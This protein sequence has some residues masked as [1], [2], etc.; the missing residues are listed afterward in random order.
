MEEKVG[1]QKKIDDFL[2]VNKVVQYS[3][4]LITRYNTSIHLYIYTSISKMNG[5]ELFERIKQVS[6]FAE[7]AQSINGKTDKETQSKRGNLYEKVWDIIIKFGFYPILSN[8]IYDHYDGNINTCKLK[9]VDNLEIYLRGLSVFSKGEGGSSDITLKNKKNGKWVFMSSKFYLD[10][11]NKSIDEY[12]VEKILAV[13]KQH[14]HKYKEFEIYLVVNNKQKVLDTIASSQST[15]NYIKENIHHILD[16]GNLEFCFQNLKDAIQDITIDEVNSKF[17][18]TKVPLLPRFHQELITYKQMKRIDEGE[19]QFLLGAKARSGKTYCIGNLL[20]KYH[21]KY[22]TINAL[23]ITPAPTETLSQFTDELFHKFRDF[24][25]INI[26]EIKKGTDFQKMGLKDKNIIIVSKQLLDDYVFEKKV[27][28]ILQLNLDFIVF[29]ENHFHGTT[30]MSKNILESYSSPK[31]IKVYLTA[32]YAKPLSEWDIPLDCQ[33]FWDIE[34]EQL[35]K[36]RDIQGL[37]EKHGEDVLLFLTEE[38]KEQMLM[39]YDIMPELHILTNMMDSER[40]AEIK[41]RIKDTSYGFSN[42]ALLSGNFPNEVDM[43]LRYITGSNKERD[44]PR[45]KDMSIFGRIKRIAI[46]K[47]SRTRL[48][49]G[50]FTSQLW[51]LP[52]GIGMPIEKVSNH[53]KDRMLKNSMLQRYEIKIVNSKKGYKVKDIKVEIK[54]WESK[55]KKDGK[56]GLILLAGDQLTLGITLDFVD[57]LFLFNDISSS[58]KI[59]QMMYR[60]MT[61]RINNP[62]NDAINDGEKKVGFVVDMNISRVLNTLL[63]YNVHKKDLNVEQ[64]ISY[65]VENNLINIDSDLFENKENKTKLVEKLLHLW[66]ADPVNNL[67]ILLRKIEDYIVNFDTKDQQRLNK[68]FMDSVGDKKI[69]VKIKFDEESDQVLPTGKEIV[70]DGDGYENTSENEENDEE[71]T[72][73]ANISFTKDILPFILP[74]ICILTMSKKN[75]DT[76]DILEMLNII[77]TTPSLLHVFNDQSF[78]WWNKK[79]IIQFIE[80]IVEKYIKRNSSIYNIAIQFKMSL[81]SLIDKPKELVELIDSCLKP[82]QKE[83]QENGEVFTSMSIISEILDNID[84]SYI[85]ACGKSVFTEKGFIWLDPAAGMGNFVVAVYLRLMDGLKLQI[86][87]DEERKKHIIENMLYM[88]E[89]NKKNVFICRQIFDVNGEYKMNIYEGDTLEL[90]I[91]SVWGLQLNSFNVILGNPAY[92]KGGIRSYTGKQLGEKNETIWPKFI[93]KAFEW[94]KPD[95]YLAFINPLSWLKKSHS[96]HNKML[97]KHIVW[98]KLWDDSQSKGMINAD[99]PISLYVLQNTVNSENKKTE[100]ISEIKRKKLTTTSLEYLNKN[101]SIPLA[102]H[103]IFNKLIRFIEKHNCNLDYKT[104]TI[105]ST[106]TKRKLPSEYLLEDMWA[107]DT[108]TLDEG[109]LVK[110]ANEQHPDANKRKLIIANKRGFKGAFIDEGKL[111]LSGTEKIYLLGD[112]LELIL[113]IMKFDISNILCDYTKYRMSFLEKEVCNYIPD[114]RKLGI[115]DITEDEFYKLIGLTCQEIRQIKNPNAN[116]VIEQDKEK[117][118]ETAMTMAM[119]KSRAKPKKKLVIVE[120]A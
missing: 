108:Y 68:E 103:S 80:E 50:D 4:I 101:Y 89:I 78:I 90:D 53:I 70:K 58:D 117:L 54:N 22:S 97:E 33:C 32:T 13:T 92:N 14:S 3:T 87:N 69:N 113:K 38:N 83:K 41:H 39:V 107:I 26:V 71:D 88:S 20:I 72:Q 56:D 19:K 85:K 99:I 37:L 55:A 11:S 79:D 75:R 98:L 96:L 16:L 51:F 17:Y 36:K 9:K 29:D 6:T 116:K 30:I 81:Q 46:E 12:D 120:D 106:G 8:D 105:K 7:L 63:D 24:N 62:E 59:I 23:I 61:E 66:K 104:K 34:D 95:G 52:Y 35:C 119:T 110:K 2:I 64:K 109:I 5:I 112:N 74:L 25:G 27:E 102:F 47:N 84:K 60:C 15:N 86:S 65:I 111:S 43:I 40:Y 118:V 82:K 73:N 94:L 91:V 10:D 31:T 115:I 28:S 45:G 114:L 21:K 76:L 93:E 48:N 44:Y 67:K 100:I 42:S 49:N 18:N 77:K 1:K 57:I